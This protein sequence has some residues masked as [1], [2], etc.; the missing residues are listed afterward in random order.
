MVNFLLIIPKSILKKGRETIK[1]MVME[2]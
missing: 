2:E 1:T